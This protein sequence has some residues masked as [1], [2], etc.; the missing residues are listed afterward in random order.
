MARAVA[1]LCARALPGKRRPVVALSRR[2]GS[3]RERLRGVPKA[4]ISDSLGK[5]RLPGAGDV[6]QTSR[7]APSVELSTFGH[8]A[9]RTANT[10]ERRE[11]KITGQG[12]CVLPAA[13]QLPGPFA[14]KCP[15]V[16]IT[17]APKVS[18]AFPWNNADLEAP[19]QVHGVSRTRPDRAL[20]W[21]A[22]TTCA[23][24]AFAMDC[25]IPRPGG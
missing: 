8:F 5:R 25:R 14:A 6:W 3:A 9:A 19:G 23:R 10:G 13:A 15:K 17:F 4:V 24:F 22:E 2:T 12:A 18:T 21:T 16:A 20:V 1:P 11:S 7:E